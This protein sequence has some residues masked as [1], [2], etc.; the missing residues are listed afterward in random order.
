MQDAT[1]VTEQVGLVFARMMPPVEGSVRSRFQRHHHAL[2]D[3]G[4]H[5]ELLLP[6]R[7]PWLERLSKIET[8]PSGSGPAQ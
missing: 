5:E 4:G 6:V 8:Q 3:L 1:R 7:N 2:G